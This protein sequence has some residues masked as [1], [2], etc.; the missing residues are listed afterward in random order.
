MRLFLVPGFRF[1]VSP[2]RLNDVS[3]LGG[4]FWFQVSGFRFCRLPIVLSSEFWVLPTVYCQLPTANCQ[5]PTFIFFLV[6]C[7][8]F[9]VS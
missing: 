7:F 9:L 2:A 5:L 6:S 1:Q 3:R 4:G 8:L